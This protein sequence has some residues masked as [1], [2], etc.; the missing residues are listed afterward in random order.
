M[1]RILK[2]IAITI[3]SLFALIV[4]FGIIGMV[5]EANDTPVITPPASAAV[6]TP[7]P[8]ATNTPNIKSVVTPSSVIAEA[9]EPSDEQDAVPETATSI[10]PIE[11]TMPELVAA[12][13]PAA[14]TETTIEPMISIS[15]SFIFTGFKEYGYTPSKTVITMNGLMP[16]YTWVSHGY[17]PEGFFHILLFEDDGTVSFDEDVYLWSNADEGI[18]IK[19]NETVRI[20]EI[21]GRGMKMVSCGS[22]YFALASDPPQYSTRQAGIANVETFSIDDILE[23]R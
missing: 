19:A 8:K 21:N 18:T 22:L 1:V 16:E 7:A 15:G 9:S 10:E 2:G 17:G 5:L 12:A 4:I 3:G 13:T 20:N 11:T 14:T 6:D 23:C